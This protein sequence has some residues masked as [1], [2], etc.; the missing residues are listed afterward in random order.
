MNE[1]EPSDTMLTLFVQSVVA[2]LVAT[3]RSLDKLFNPLF[4]LGDALRLASEF[5]VMFDIVVDYTGQI[6][7]HGYVDPGEEISFEWVG[8]T[9]DPALARAITRWLYEID[10]E[11][12]RVP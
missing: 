9:G 2:D 6:T 12:A 1:L 7:V 4:H 8:P 5:D 3:S 10:P 11:R